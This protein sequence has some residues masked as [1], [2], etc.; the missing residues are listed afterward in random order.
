MDCVLVLFVKSK[1]KVYY[2]IPRRNSTVWMSFLMRLYS[3]IDL[4]GSVNMIEQTMSTK[5][6]FYRIISVCFSKKSLLID[7]LAP[8]H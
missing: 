3:S 1:S 6:L 7:V 4:T 2:L 8:P 5:L